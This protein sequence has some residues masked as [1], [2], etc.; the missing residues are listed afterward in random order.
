MKSDEHGSASA[1]TEVEEGSTT[2]SSAGSPGHDSSGASANM[3]P[4]GADGNGPTVFSLQHF[5][6]KVVNSLWGS[7]PDEAQPDD[8]SSRDASSSSSIE[9]PQQHAE[10]R[11]HTAEGAQ[12]SAEVQDPASPTM[13]SRSTND[14]QH[15]T[16]EAPASFSDHR[17]ASS[18]SGPQQTSSKTEAMQTGQAGA[19]GMPSTLRSA[20]PEFLPHKFRAGHKA[21]V[22]NFED[23]YKAAYQETYGPALEEHDSLQSALA[24]SVQVSTS[25]SSAM[26]LSNN[27]PSMSFVLGFAS[28]QVAPARDQC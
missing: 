27:G 6:P 20:V 10:H 2:N 1:V 13:Q 26:A 19:F 21:S 18:T 8:A 15:D 5:F 28:S 11:H 24:E 7:T 16:A 4:A 14:T 9:S 17:S 23:A 3:S 12:H 25:S 22:A